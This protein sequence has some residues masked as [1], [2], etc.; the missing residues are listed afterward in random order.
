MAG[1]GL[2][3]VRSQ[4]MEGFTGNLTEY[5]VADDNT[6]AIFT[7]DVVT[8]NGGFVEEASGATSGEDFDILGV[9]QGCRFIDADGSIEYRRH[10]DGLAGRSDVKAFVAVP[11]HSVF[12]IK[13]TAGTTYTQADIGVRKGIVYA[14][15]DATTG[16]SR[17][18]LGANAATGPLI[19]NASPT[20]PATPS[21][22]TS[23]SS[24]CRWS[25]RSSSRSSH[26][27]EAHQCPPSIA[28]R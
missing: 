9:F 18:T 22:W 15:G 25:A 14:A 8:L 7:G 4:G 17:I 20:F 24:R 11:P 26:P 19:V 3:L 23:R 10:W 16:D 28:L 6:D 2:R 27:K 12:Y 5:P 1:N 21:G 13:G